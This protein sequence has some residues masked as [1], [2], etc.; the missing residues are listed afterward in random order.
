MEK[1]LARSGEG[2]GGGGEGGG[3]EDGGIF[4]NSVV[5][6]VVKVENASFNFPGRKKW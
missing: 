3:G 4:S 5:V 6:P 2:E 1:Y